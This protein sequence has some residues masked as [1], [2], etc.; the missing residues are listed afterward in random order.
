MTNPSHSTPFVSNNRFAAAFRGATASMAMAAIGLLLVAAIGIAG[1]DNLPWATVSLALMVRVLPFAFFF[2]AVAGLFAKGACNG[3]LRQSGMM[4][5][6]LVLV[7]PYFLTYKGLLVASLISSILLG[8]LATKRREAS[9]SRGFTQL[10]A[11]GFVFSLLIALLGFFPADSTAESKSSV[12]TAVALEGDMRPNIVLVV[13]DT[14]RASSMSAYGYARDTTPFLTEFADRGILWE[15]AESTGNHTPPGHASLF[16]GLYPH[17]HGVM[18]TSVGLPAGPETLAERLSNRGYLTSGIVSNYVIRGAS[19]FGRGFQLYDDSM[20]VATALERIFGFV[21]RET[22]HGQTWGVIPFLFS[23]LNLNKIFNNM[24][25]SRDRLGAE[26]QNRLVQTQL[27]T[28]SQTGQPAF[29]FLNY[30]Q[31]H[32]PYQA[33]GEW[34]DKYLSH[35]PAEF[36]ERMTGLEFSI[37]LKTLAHKVEIGE[38]NAETVAALQDRYDAEIAYLDSQLRN[39]EEIIAQESGERPWV[40]IVTSDH[41]EHFGEHSL[42]K[43]GGGLFEETQHIPL[44]A[45][46]TS[47][48]R[49][50]VASETVSLIDV[51]GTVL[52]LA[53]IKEP[54]GHSRSLLAAS[55]APRKPSPNVVFSESGPLGV[56]SHFYPL[57]T[58][59]VYEGAKKTLV[60]VDEELEIF[61]P[62]TMV[63]LALDP[64]EASPSAFSAKQIS[65]W[66]KQQPWVAGWWQSYLAGRLRTS[67][68][69]VSDSDLSSLNE[70]GYAVDSLDE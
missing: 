27:R 49:G 62:L 13:C 23:R 5:G 64:A 17:E 3:A 7:L 19:G 11:A 59:A 22:A 66:N 67:Q 53:G 45:V 47:L 25:R 51:P 35:D 68:V 18:A 37:K 61:S 55:G 39:L 32:A 43:H 48:A 70:I 6:V 33:P 34:F 38:G 28:L 65:V 44:I 9:N 54:L 10:F 1:Q 20:V 50:Q 14:L 16:T 21:G 4:V 58:V 15:R 36:R 24:V 29:L 8:Y 41:G 69:T 31:A 30:M 63:D 56:R 46:G 26:W 12:E 42:M 2:G 57:T 52:A 40:M 60:Q